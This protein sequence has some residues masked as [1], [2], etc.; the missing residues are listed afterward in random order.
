MLSV[1][2]IRVGLIGGGSMARAHVRTMLQRPAETR[3][4]AVAE[5][6]A[7][8]YE[9]LALQFREIGLPPP[10][11]YCDHLQLL[12]KHAH[13][14]D[15]ALISTPHAQHFEQARACLAAR[16]DVLLEKPMVV[17]VEEAQAL[18]AARDQSGRLLVVA[19]QGS[20]SPQVREAARLVQS[21]E[22][23]A[24]QGI[25]GYLWQ[26]WEQMT[27]NTW[28]Q[29][30]ELSG[31][32]FLFDTGAHLLN[33]VSDIAGEPFSAVAAWLDTRG[34]PV[35]IRGT[36]MARTHSGALITLH[37][38]GDSMQGVGSEVR[39]WCERGLI[40]TGQWGERLLVQ[41]EGQA[42]PMPVDLPPRSSAWEQFLAVRAGR[43]PNPCPPEVGLRMAHLWDAIRRSAALGGAP[44]QL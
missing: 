2:P 18:I 44:V 35:D 38:I 32:G 8:A 3:V 26:C 34:R 14:L 24:L 31:G 6:E 20:L 23:G 5:P 25:Q 30:P 1:T 12:E 22:L 17:T 39:I 15:A 28:R 41:R 10:A 37:A 36:V 42:E 7:T 13:E 40:I 27:R 4:V 21:G 9:Q 43:L 19:F 29:Q 33:T 16:L 11:H